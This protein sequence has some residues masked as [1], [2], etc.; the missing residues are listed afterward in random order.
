MQTVRSLLRN[1]DIFYLSGID[2]EES[3]LLLF[4]D[5]Q[6][7]EHRE[8]LFIKKTSEIIAVWE[9]QKL[10]PKQATALSGIQTVCWLYEFENYFS[11]WQIRLKFFILIPTNTI[12]QR[13]KLKPG[14]PIY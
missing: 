1:I 14:G 10:T 7:P 6:E 11:Y 2:Q 8:I 4:P 5:A 3:I 9:G 13:W 12:G